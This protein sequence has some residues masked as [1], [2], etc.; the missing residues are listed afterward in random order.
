[1]ATL[2]QVEEVLLQLLRR[3]GTVD[4][5][6]RAMLPSQRLIEARCPDLDLVRHAQ[7][8]G[9][10]IELLT[11]EPGRRPDIRLSVLSDDLLRI[12][13]GDLPVSRAIASN[14]LRVDASMPDLLRLRAAL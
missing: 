2:E 9:G 12:A 14:R 10:V 5:S 13:A 7:W 8:R 6:A 4:E 1:M 3:L 11:D